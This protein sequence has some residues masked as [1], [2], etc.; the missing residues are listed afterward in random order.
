MRPLK[1]SALGICLILGAGLSVGQAADR[2]VRLLRPRAAAPALVWQGA[3]FLQA[4]GRGNVYLLRGELDAMDVYPLRDGVAG[5][6]VRLQLSGA[7]GEPVTQAALSSDGR[8]WAVATPQRVFLFDDGEPSAMPDVGWFVTSLAMVRDT[9]VLGVLPMAVGLS[10]T[11]RRPAAP[12]LLL[13]FEGR[14][15]RPFVQGSYAERSKTLDPF[16][17]L[18]TEH[19]VELAADARG[20]SWLIHPF[21][22]KVTRYSPA[23]RLEQRMVLGSG[24]AQHK[25]DAAQLRREFDRKLRVRGLRS[26]NATTGVF[27][28]KLAVR[29]A[30]VTPGGDLY[31]LLDS[32]L[33][34]SGPALARYDN[35]HHRV[36]TAPLSFAEEG[37]VTMAAGRE[38]IYLASEIE[39]RRR[40]LLP[41]AQVEAAVWTPWEQ[42]RIEGAPAKAA[43]AR[44][45]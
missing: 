15:W 9:P 33:T 10:P 36:E 28:G 37:E 16:N 2:G 39:G 6:P 29:G 17:A 34:R 45:R 41:W 7:V 40:W 4:D 22:G 35:V 18:F 30:T 13:R 12:P 31:L 24:I 38:G 42:T 14:E 25:E 8:R 3:Q 32:V 1:A 20:R 11:A 26:S 43:V 21:T 5:E 44:N 27:T 19:T 23:G